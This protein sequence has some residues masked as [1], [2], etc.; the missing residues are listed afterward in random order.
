MAQQHIPHVGKPHAVAGLLA[1][2]A[3]Q[4]PIRR[5]LHVPLHP[6][7]HREKVFLPRFAHPHIDLRRVRL[8]CGTDGV[9]QQICQ[10]G[11]H[12]HPA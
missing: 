6:V 2:G 1:G 10:H 12:I 4:L 3:G 9:I 7:A 5:Q 11:D 8:R